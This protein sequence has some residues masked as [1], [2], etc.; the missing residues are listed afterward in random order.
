MKNFIKRPLPFLLV[1]LAGFSLAVT[2]L[3]AAPPAS[4]YSPGETLD[5]TCAPGDTNCSVE[6]NDVSSSTTDDLSEGSS[7]LY[8]TEARVSANSD[9]AANTTSR[10]NALSL[11]GSLDYLSLTGQT[12][13][14]NE[15]DVGT[16][17]N[18]TAG[19]GVSLSSGTLDVD[20]SGINVGDLNTNFTTGSI[21][22]SNGTNL[23]QDN[24][25][26]F[27]DDTNDRLGLGTNLP[28]YFLEVAGGDV[29]VTQTLT[30]GWNLSNASYDSVS[31]G[32]SGEALEPTGTY[33]KPDGTK[34]YLSDRS[35]NNIYQYTLSTP[36]DLSTAAYDT[37]SF[38]GQAGFPRG[39]FLK[40]D[41]TK[42]YELDGSTTY[43]YTLSTPWDLS[44][45]SYDSVSFSV[46]GQ[47]SDAQ[48][49]A[50]KSD[51][52]K[53]YVIGDN[54]NTVYQYGLS[55]PWDLSTA[56]YDSVSFS[57][58]G[59]EGISR[60]LA[61][62]SDGAKMYIVG[63][64]ANS[65][66]QYSLSTPWDL[67]TA[68]YDSV[69]F[70]VSNEVTDSH[71]VSFKTNGTKMFVLDGD[72]SSGRIYQYSMAGGSEGGSIFVDNSIG[73]GATSPQNALDVSGA[74]VIGSTYAGTN[75]A[76]TNGLLVE[77]NVGIGTTSPNTAFDLSGAFSLRGVSV[78][79]TAP[80]GQGRIYFDSSSNSFKVSEDGSSYENLLSDVSAAGSDG[81]VQFNSSGSFGA[82]DANFFWDDTNDRLGLGT[83]TPGNLLHLAG[84]DL[85]IEETASSG[86]Y[87]IS[88]ASFSQS[89]STQNSLSLSI[90]WND[91]GTKLYE[92]GRGSG[93][94][95]LYEYNVSTPYDISTASFSKSIPT[96]DSY[97]EGIAWNDDGSK[98]Y[99]VGQGSDLIYEYDV[100][101]PYDINSASF[102]QSIS[103]QDSIPRG[104]TW[105]DDGTKLYEMGG[106]NSELIYEYDVST[107]YDISTASFSL[108]IS[109]QDGSPEGIAWN[110]DGSKLYE[111]GRGSDL[112]YEYDVSTPYNISTASFS[113]SIS[114]QDSD[115]TGIAWNS[116][117]SKLYEIGYDGL[118]GGGY[119][120]E[121]D[122]GN[123]FEGGTLIADT[124]VGIGTTT[125]QNALDVSGSSVVGST[126]AGTNTA[127]TNGLL[128][129]GNVGLG[130]TSPSARL[131]SLSTTEQLRLGY[132]ASNYLSAT[133]GS[134]GSTTLSLTGTSPEF[135]FSQLANFSSG[136][137]VN[138]ETITDFT[139]TGLTLNTNAL[140][141]DQ[142]A[143]NVEG[144]ATAL[145]A[146]SI[147]FSD[148]S[149][150][151]EDNANL[152]WDNANNRL[153][154]G[155]TSPNT[156]LDLAGA[157]SIR[158]M[159]APSTAPSGQGR[160]YFDSS[161]NTFKVSEN[162]GSYEN[163]LGG[164]SVAGSDGAVQFNSSGSFG[165]D[166]ANLFWDNS[167]KMLGLGTTNPTDRLHVVDASVAG[168][169]YETDGVATFEDDDANLQVVATDQGDDAAA[170][171]LTNAPAGGTGDNKHWIMQHRGANLNNRLDLGYKTSAG[172]GS[173]ATGTY[174]GMTLLTNGNVGIG[175]TSPGRNLHAVNNV[176]IG[177][178]ADGDGDLFL[179]DSSGNQL[180]QLDTEGS[181][182]ISGT[183]IYLTAGGNSYINTGG[184]VG[185]GTTS[186]NEELEIGALGTATS[187]SD[188]YDSGDIGL[189]AS[190][191]DVNGSN[192]RTGT[193]KIRNVTE[194]SNYPDFD[195]Q[196]VDPSDNTV[197]TLTGLGSGFTEGNV[198]I[199]T[200]S[201][202]KKLHV[203]GSARIGNWKFNDISS[204]ELA[205]TDSGNNTVLIFDESNPHIFWS[206]NLTDE[207]N[208]GTL[209]RTKSTND[210]VYLAKDGS[211]ST[212]NTGE[213]LTKVRE[214][215]YIVDF[216]R[217]LA[218]VNLPDGAT[219]TAE[220]R[221]SDDNFTTTKDSV[222]VELE[223]GM[224]TYDLAE[225]A[226]ASYYRILFEFE[227]NN[228]GE[229]P[230][231]IFFETASVSD[232]KKPRNLA[233]TQNTG[234][235]ETTTSTEDEIRTTELGSLPIGTGNYVQITEDGTL[236][237][238]GSSERF[239]RDITKLTI[240]TDMI[241]DLN[242]R[243][244]IW[245][246][247]TENAGQKDFGLVAEEVDEVLPELT[248]RGSSGELRGVDYSKLS[249]LMLGELQQLDLKVDMLD[250]NL[251]TGGSVF[252]R[253]LEWFEDKTLR[254]KS[255]R[256]EEVCV[257]DTCV[258]ESE[259]RQLLDNADIDPRSISDP[260]DSDS[261]NETD[262]TPTTGGGSDNESQGGDD[263]EE[264]TVEDSED[265]QNDSKEDE[266]EG[267]TTEK[268]ESS[269]E[270][271]S[272]EE[273]DEED[274]D[275]EDE[276]NTDESDPETEQTT[277]NSDEE[278]DGEN[279]TEDNTG[280]EK[281]DEDSTATEDI[282]KESD[283]ET[284]EGDVEVKDKGSEKEEG[285]VKGEE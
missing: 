138:S 249:V 135:T 175:T 32:V 125:P 285:S 51:G 162:G 43:Q 82:D 50:L 260:E 64:G 122:M 76:P 112:I 131:H 220:V 197:M 141:V 223:D 109:T 257:G 221:S 7:N 274:K 156:L 66:F 121:Y 98:L 178:T 114:T 84:G 251:D 200:S 11:G 195:L 222:T 94:E 145:T 148:G 211:G 243:S 26:L 258:N 240:D 115:P 261:A 203:N 254:V 192:E 196:F 270:Q 97:P 207:F 74:S 201:P 15:I 90:A 44:T 166:D 88:T 10:H 179:E 116:D 34:M 263:N 269:D 173:I 232:E 21:P 147:P 139:G 273:S 233:S 160:I 188:D 41:G 25:N 65:V 130:T 57:V 36:W 59:Q 87:D 8:Y 272:V 230:E 111:V 78:P 91:D 164:A 92:T 219:L 54:N 265:T 126:Y 105:N 174:T 153:G 16:D 83:A 104:I 275:T 149:N 47:E 99:E 61:F 252:E 157:L 6:T 228:S 181:S 133:V 137:N 136:V 271:E 262:T 276:E 31:F 193:W 186:P 95:R 77:G 9:V 191:W 248:F 206:Q 169:H 85:R 101:T 215:P 108:S 213:Y 198:G 81:A 132:D 124:S 28:S 70:D 167:G 73:I 35:S 68:S 75:T 89:I 256:T 140:T 171:I 241:Y 205:V 189:T 199:G 226:D 278:N 53:M 283:D 46:S 63:D 246:D 79:S 38:D 250:P 159:S 30:N 180:I 60:E 27:W 216:E 69:S 86:N 102:S 49:L 58:S 40:S 48:G 1:I 204:T 282:T 266:T 152:F 165:A 120:Y 39:V 284:S 163:L 110:N 154:L 202:S 212:H 172:S 103:T 161:S 45:A 22:F 24:T 236:V 118:S 107:P 37:V 238:S 214:E 12:L 3:I 253:L 277:E 143:L 142:T 168:A 113:Q 267:S 187:D 62:K 134:A 55:T 20:T 231:L 209:T 183:Q 127:P 158:G 235:I 106:H 255:L 128:V 144:F 247:N 71:G 245:D 67:S 190:G 117:G 23:T 119:I 229:T 239:K 237:E 56:S 150:L 17:T 218:T 280:T 123:S 176:L 42:M 19:S 264:T 5:P 80:A 279:K 224:K 72:F 155:T 14:L 52:T 170:F 96:Q 146:G 244:F 100:S 4:K 210:R 93:A 225:L 185:I 33:F 242:P 259:L 184:N 151:T 2:A 281:N 13:T 18:L 129:E 234:V 208:T 217:I 194:P 29:Y 182:A 268:E 177:G 227:A